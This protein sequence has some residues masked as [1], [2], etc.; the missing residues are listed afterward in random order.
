MS[1]SCNHGYEYRQF[2]SDPINN[3]MFLSPVC[4][5]EVINEINK[6]VN[7]NVSGFDNFPSNL[8]KLS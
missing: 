7:S 6:L 2:L 3:I 5:Q 8:V 4:Q 1:K